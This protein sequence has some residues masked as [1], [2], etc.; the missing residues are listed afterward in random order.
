MF[1]HLHIANPNTCHG[2][3]VDLQ[4][5]FLSLKNCN[6]LSYLFDQHAPKAVSYEYDRAGSR[7]V[8]LA[9]LSQIRARGS[10]F[11]VDR[12]TAPVSKHQKY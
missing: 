3:V 10:V 8:Q 5:P 12:T 2:L 1:L 7:L 11:T 9:F 6:V 4:Y